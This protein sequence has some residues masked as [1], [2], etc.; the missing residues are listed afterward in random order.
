MTTTSSSLLERLK[1]A[2]PDAADWQRLQ[3]LYL[4]LIRFWVAR[5][6][7]LREDVD[8]LAQEVLLVLF[9]ELPSFERRRDGAFRA[10]LRQI[11]TNRIRA[12]TRSKKRLP[13]A[14]SGGEAENLLAQLEDP[15]GDLAQQWDQEHDQQVFRKL[16]AVIQ[17]DFE[18]STW[19]AFKRFAL[20]GTPAAQVA[21]DLGLSQSAVIQ[22][23]FRIVKR[24]REEFGDLLA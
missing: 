9:R 20:D 18:P 10:W 14:G 4:P 2:K 7:W 3:D 11:T 13:R 23:K 24:L 1:H 17:P 21:Q 6:P 12:F 19:L 16:L 15:N 5:V 22:G 8:D